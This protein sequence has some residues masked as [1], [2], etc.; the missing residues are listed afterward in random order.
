MRIIKLISL[1]VLLYCS[2]TFAQSGQV[3]QKLKTFKTADNLTE[4]IYERL[5]Y[6]NEDPI[7][8]IVFLNQTHQQVWRQA[9]NDDEYYA[10]LNL[11][12]TEGYIHLLNADILGSISAYEKALKYYRDHQI[13]TYDIFEYVLK[14][15]TNNYTRLGDYDKALYL[16]QISIDYLKQDPASANIR[17]GLYGNIAI[18]YR[19]MGNLA[20]AQQMTS[21]GLQ[22][23]KND[24]DALLMLKNIQADILF[25]KHE[26][27]EAA[28]IIDQNIQRI[29]QITAQN[30][31]T[32]MG[33]FA[34]A[35]NIYLAL[36][37]TAKA[38]TYFNRALALLDRFYSNTRLRERANIYTQL[39]N[40]EL[41][42]SNYSKALAFFNRTL[43]TLKVADQTGKLFHD[44]IYGDNKLVE[45]FTLMAKA[46]VHL[47]QYDKGLDLIKLSLLSANKIR[48]EFTDDLTK[49]RLQASFK[50]IA[51]QGID[52]CY[53]RYAQTKDKKY[54]KPVLDFMEQTKSRTLLDHIQNTAYKLSEHTK[55]PLFNQKKSIERAIVYQEKEN[56]ETGR[57]DRS[58][59]LNKLKF[60]LAQVEKQLRQKYK[61]LNAS[62][63]TY[64]QTVNLSALTDAKILSYFWGNKNIYLI[65]IDHQQL[66]NLIRVEEAPQKQIL[67]EQFIQDYYKNGPQK[68]LNNPESFFKDSHQIYQVFLGKV[69]I[70]PDEMLTIIP[71]ETLNYLSFDGLITDSNFG[72]R[73]SQ[74]PFLIKNSTLKYAFSLHTLLAKYKESGSIKFTGLFITHEQGNQTILESVK[75]EATSLKQVLSGKFIT[76]A[77]INRKNF[78]DVFE[79]SGILHIGTHAYL[80]GAHLE[81][82]LDLG[83]EKLYLFELAGKKNAPA[84]IILTA[85]KTADGFL[86][87]GEGV[88]SFSR[89]FN[90][91]GTPSVIAGLWNVNDKAAAQISK[92]FYQYLSQDKS[93]AEALHLAK[94]AWLNQTQPNDA[95]YLPYYWDSLIYSGKDQHI[96]IK[97]ASDPVIMWIGCLSVLIVLSA[98]LI[99]KWKNL[100]R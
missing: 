74:W 65:E 13:L 71:D 84:L 53:E 6:V 85:C 88:I 1:L 83:T 35:G 63:V 12:S 19:S 44:R 9:K 90:A 39:G 21:N 43:T 80:S 95:Y 24:Q 4:W 60:E 91:M 98:I 42:D 92:N 41:I 27:I 29:G 96:K 8:R 87:N 76:D 31:Y 30:A 77:A 61:Q 40:I 82:T 47:E 2:T 62:A 33:T 56:L 18:C 93:G 64:N 67:L 25:E 5:A 78:N 32:T 73:I 57:T 54:L 89:G 52:Y 94:L 23:V 68:A 72:Y 70:K 28:R 99:F 38:K 81:P 50:N 58:A 49:Q 79:R 48:N 17:A 7:N 36:R 45:V 100:I 14:P 22:L 15:L 26:L 20:L 86:A 51:E 46:Y 16:L 37:Q 69:T 97:K 66:T 11:L 59:S 75:E 10:W 55:D 3:T 34:T